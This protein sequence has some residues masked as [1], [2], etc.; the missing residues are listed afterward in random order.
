MQFS[1]I[2]NYNLYKIG[3]NKQIFIEKGSAAVL[4]TN[5]IR[6]IKYKIID[7]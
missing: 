1:N 7:L 4:D 5:L 2:I 6:K 3:N